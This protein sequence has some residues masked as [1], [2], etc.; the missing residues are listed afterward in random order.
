MVVETSEIEHP[1]SN[2]AYSAGVIATLSDLSS[3][4]FVRQAACDE[5]EVLCEIVHDSSSSLICTLHNDEQ[6]G[7]A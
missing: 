6:S 2:L 1:M 4:G 7:T 5:T 3:S